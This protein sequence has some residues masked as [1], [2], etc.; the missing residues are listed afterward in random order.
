MNREE[1]NRLLGRYYSGEST[2]EEENNLREYFRRD[3]IPEGYD[4]EKIIFGFYTTE[5]EIPEPSHGFEARLIEGID[6]YENKH[7]AREKRRLILSFMSAAAGILILVASYF[8]LVQRSNSQDTF[9][10]PQIA[11]AET[12]KILMDVSS[13]LNRGT[14]S[15]EPVGRINKIPAES[16]NSI[17]RPS[18]LIEKNMKNLEYL[19]KAIEIV[20]VPDKNEKLNNQ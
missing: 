1:L 13:R 7:V 8:L 6:A 3:D 2:G 11:Y 4:A 12:M 20:N 5:N 16:F 19:K 10:D 18:T 14:Q 9:K 17:N 15:L